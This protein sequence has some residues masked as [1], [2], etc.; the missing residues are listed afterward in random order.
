MTPETATGARGQLLRT[1]QW[2][3]DGKRLV[4]A[5]EAYRTAR[6]AASAEVPAP[7]PTKPKRKSYQLPPLDTPT[8]LP[9]YPLNRPRTSTSPTTA[10][11]GGSRQYGSRKPRG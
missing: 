10:I 1:A 5:V 3:K 2:I 8:E 9:G 7:V 6:D 4:E 11:S